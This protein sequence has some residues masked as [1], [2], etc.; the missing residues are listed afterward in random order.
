MIAMAALLAAQ[1]KGD[2]DDDFLFVIA[3][4]LLFFA[5]ASGAGSSR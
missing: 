2:K 3:F 1:V 4:C 5:I